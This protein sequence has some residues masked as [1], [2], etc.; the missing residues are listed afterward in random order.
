MFFPF[1]SKSFLFLLP[2]ALLANSTP[3]ESN[4]LDRGDGVYI[5]D[6]TGQ[7]AEYTPLDKIEE[8]AL[9]VNATEVD[10]SPLEARDA[11]KVTCFKASFWSGSKDK[12]L[13]QFL[14][15]ANY[16]NVVPGDSGAIATQY[17]NAIVYGCIPSRR[18]QG[19]LPAIA[20]QASKDLDAKCKPGIA[21]R[22][23][24]QNRLAFGRTASGKPFCN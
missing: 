6:E 8:R 17:G 15:L 20:E 19:G 22:V 5:R 16:L 1:L 9:Q 7:I 3:I 10:F 4:G 12:A 2:L 23:D 14:P 21:G 24:F 11:G 18:T 13:Q